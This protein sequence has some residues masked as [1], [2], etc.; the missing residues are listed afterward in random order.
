MQH[1]PQLAVAALAASSKPDGWQPAGVYLQEIRNQIIDFYAANPPRFGP[2]WTCPMDVGIRAANWLVAIDI[3]R[4]AGWQLDMPFQRLLIDSLYDHGHHIIGHLEWSESGR[5]NHYLSD[6]V[7]LLFIAAYLPPSE[8]TNAWLAFATSE[9]VA[10]IE[11]QFHNDGGNY[12][13][14]TSY[15]RLSGE[16]SIFGSALVVGLA[17]EAQS[18]FTHFES[19]HLAGIRPPVPQAPLP[20]FETG[21]TSP[22]TEKAVSRLYRL[23]QFTNAILRPDNSIPQIGDTDSGRLFKLHPVWRDDGEEDLLDHR[24]LCAASGA[25]FAA[26]SG[27]DWLD[28]A[29]VRALMA[30]RSL[31]DPA[32]P[33]LASASNVAAQKEATNRVV[34]L[35]E[36][37][38]RVVS[39][40]L[41]SIAENRS[42]FSFP[43]FGLYILKGADFYLAFR[44]V[45]SIRT[46][47]PTG[48]LHDDNLSIELFAEGR[49]LVCD[50][51]TYVYTS[52]PSLRNAYRAASAHYAPRV[53]GNAV[54]E[55][56]ADLLFQV[57][58]RTTARLIHAGIE[59]F[60][61]EIVFPDGAKLLR[62]IEIADQTLTISDGVID[63]RLQPLALPLAFSSGYGKKS[64]IF[65]DPRFYGSVGNCAK[66]DA[67]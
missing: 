60:A 46:D 39:I 64:N 41:A 29:V 38:R 17:G 9:L 43:N 50:P 6:I 63:G 5:S 53:S 65:V 57:K 33:T 34:A 37:S 24:H 8:L 56:N 2:N 52:V 66:A 61:A 48:H 59:G 32:A 20:Q 55:I 36:E 35:P 49:S 13:G 23:G 40:K 12:E 51:G 10:E 21:T 3:A 26:A 22:L 45:Q 7:G 1:L 15:H 28:A 30:G 54:F 14:S 16:L 27:R 11:R 4:N 19:A 42:L 47:A 62:T 31:R 25:I 58:P 67:A 18:A 44:C